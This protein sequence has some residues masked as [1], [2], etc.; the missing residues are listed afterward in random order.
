MTR[1]A[2]DGFRVHLLNQNR[3]ARTVK[4]HLYRLE[5]LYNSCPDFSIEQLDTFLARQ[6]EAGNK[7]SNLNFFIS[8]IRSFAQYKGLNEHLDHFKYR[9]NEHYERSTMSDGEIEAF[10]RLTRPKGLWQSMWEM[11]NIYFSI[12]FFTGMRPIEV[13]SLKVNDIDFGLGV[14][15]IPPEVDKTINTRQG[16]RVPTTVPLP[17]NI[18]EQLK[19]YLAALKTTLL[20]PAPRGGN[21]EFNGVLDTSCICVHFQKR[22]KLLGIKRTNLTPYSAR[23]SYGTRL[24]EEDVNLYTIKNLLRH[25]K[26]ETTEIYLH[27]GLKALQKGQAKHPLIQKTLSPLVCLQNLEEQLRWVMDDTRFSQGFRKG[28]IDLIFGE[29]QKF[30]ES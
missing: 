4:M 22:L 14:I 20:F 27:A 21:G 7:N 3:K 9:P 17:P 6:K 15:H 28:L 16:N 2:L 19:A 29:K 24:G 5:R 10:L 13:A 12:L 25:S 8:S 1:L 26:I 18:S 11:Y 30:I 23:H